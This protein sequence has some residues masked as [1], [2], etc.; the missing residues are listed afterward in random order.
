VNNIPP[1]DLRVLARCY[2]RGRTKVCRHYQA[3]PQNRAELA[4]K[5]RALAEAAY[6]SC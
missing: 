4:R 6:F 3:Y 5:E 1:Q 2:Y